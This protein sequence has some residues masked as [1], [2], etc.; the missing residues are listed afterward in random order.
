VRCDPEIRG[1]KWGEDM[2]LTEVSSILWRERELLELLLFKLEEEQL[3]LAAGRTR[4]LGHATREVE[5]VLEELR[6]A[7]LGRA[8]EVDA[9]ASDLGLP[10]NPSLRELAELAP[11]PWNDIL[12]EHRNAFLII[13]Q[14]ITALAKTNREL[15][16]AGY[17]AARETLMS[18]GEPEVQTYSPDGQSVQRSSGPRLLNEAI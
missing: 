15:L 7:E 12:R 16:S 17:R 18:L 14:E 2:S 13:A 5:M 3:L 11:A 1:V 8:V 6:R 4:W 9:L 10:S